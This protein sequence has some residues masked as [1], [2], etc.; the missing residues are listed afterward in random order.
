MISRNSIQKEQ[1]LAAIENGEFEKSIIASKS[2]VVIILTQDWCP[3]WLDMKSWIYDL[4]IDSDV[5]LYE[6]EYN[7]TDYAED[8]MKFK[9]NNF[10]NDY[11]PYLRFYK[12]GILVK[13]TNYIGKQEFIDIIRNM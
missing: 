7:T 3:Q 5:D 11:V 13:E 4:E 9:E 10:G 2:S 8:F 12:Q 6:L 1:A